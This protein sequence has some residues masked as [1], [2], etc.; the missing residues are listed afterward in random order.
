LPDGLGT[1]HPQFTHED[2]LALWT[3]TGGIPRY[4]D[5]LLSNEA[6]SRDAMFSV[7]FGRITSFIDEGKTTF[8]EI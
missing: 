6:Y 3:I 5:L 4:I 1:Y 7:V 2:L 8:A